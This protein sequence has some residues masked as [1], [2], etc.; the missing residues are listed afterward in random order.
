MTPEDKDKAYKLY[1]DMAESHTDT[2]LADDREMALIEYRAYTAEITRRKTG[3]SLG[4]IVTL[5]N[6]VG[7]GP[8]L[9]CWVVQ[10]VGSRTLYLYGG[11]SNVDGYS[12]N[13]GEVV[14]VAH[15]RDVLDA[16]HFNRDFDSY[17]LVWR[18]PLDAPDLRARLQDPG[19]YEDMQ[20]QTLFWRSDE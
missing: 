15:R 16:W 14:L 18:W 10:K 1:A 6:Y 11:G 3:I 4:D 2:G 7:D 9:P 13:L 19:W 12:A 17:K 5:K 20:K 8:L